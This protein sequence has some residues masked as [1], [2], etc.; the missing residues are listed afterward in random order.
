MVGEYSWNK[1]LAYQRAQAMGREFRI[2]GVNVLLGPVV[3]P[4]GRVAESGRNWEGFSPDPYL[5]GELVQ[6]TVKGIQENGVITSVKVYALCFWPKG[7]PCLCEK[8]D[9]KLI[10][11]ALLAAFYRQRARNQPERVLQWCGRGSIVQ[12]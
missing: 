4:I 7:N 5:S 1:D 6:G 10:G 11:I 9:E 8:G 12:Y 2:K 3:G